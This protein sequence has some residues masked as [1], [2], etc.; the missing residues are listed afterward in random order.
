MEASQYDLWWRIANGYLHTSDEEI[1]FLEEQKWEHKQLM[2]ENYD[3]LSTK[4][5][6][7]IFGLLPKTQSRKYITTEELLERVDLHELIS[8]YTQPKLVRD[9]ECMA[10]CPFHEDRLE[11][12]SYN[13]QKQVWTC[14]AG[15]GGGT[16]IQF[17]MKAESIDYLKAKNV[18]AALV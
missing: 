11:S 12:L 3:W 16:A 7:T 6:K 18:L 1:D 17:L 8:Q 2:K 5:L 13:R 4:R 15:C 14:F 10:K 9:G